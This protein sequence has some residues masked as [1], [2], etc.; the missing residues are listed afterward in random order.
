MIVLSQRSIM[1]NPAEPVHGL[2][3]NFRVSALTS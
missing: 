1:T 2:D 3:D